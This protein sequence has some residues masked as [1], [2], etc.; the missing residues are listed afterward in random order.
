[1]KTNQITERKTQQ[2]QE[3]QK[4]RTDFNQHLENNEK[5]LYSESLKTTE[6]SLVSIA[7]TLF[8]ICGFPFYLV[9]GFTALT[10][11]LSE[12]SLSEF[13]Q[14]VIWPA[15]I[16]LAVAVISLVLGLACKAFYRATQGANGTKFL[17]TGK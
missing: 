13:G 1:M 3:I 10:A 8:L 6:D 17:V 4:D 14:E 9:I 2:K 15:A 5:I 12:R 7:T 16:L 11:Y